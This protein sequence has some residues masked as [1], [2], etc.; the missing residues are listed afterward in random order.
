M[1]RVETVF[2]ACE[3]QVFSIFQMFLTVKTVFP[4]SGFYS[5]IRLVE[6]DFLSSVKCIL[7][8]RSFAE[9]FEIRRWQFMLVETDF[10]ANRTFFPHFSDTP[11]SESYF[12]SSE[13]V[14]L[15]ESSS[16][17]G[18]GV[19]SVLWKPL[20]LICNLFSLQVEIVP[21]TSGGPFFWGKTLFQ[22]TERV[23]LCSENCFLLFRASF[24]QV[25][26]ATETS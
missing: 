11:S 5:L 2:L 3:K 6:T 20:S 18:G 24:L 1:L 7:F 8:I 23:F 25:K 16:P 15:N 19:F 17:C 22:L 10:L 13:N 9:T 26:A 14:C 4:S 12:P 21:E